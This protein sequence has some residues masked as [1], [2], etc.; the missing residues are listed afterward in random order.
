MTILY[1][2]LPS[3]PAASASAGAS[4][5]IAEHDSFLAAGIEASDSL[6]QPDT[7]A[8]RYAAVADSGAI[9]QQGE[10][11]LEE[12]AGLVTRCSRVVLLVAA[13]DVTL[14]NIVVPP[15]SAARLRAALPNLIE[16][17]LIGDAAE[18]AFVAGPAVNGRRTVAVVAHDWLAAWSQ[19]LRS[20]GA[21]QLTALPAQLCLPW[22]SPAADGAT[23]T[24]PDA[25]GEQAE[26]RQVTAAAI[27]IHVHAME[28]SLRLSSTD[29]LGLTI[30]A[31]VSATEPSVTATAADVLDALMALVPGRRVMALVPAQE[32]ALFEFLL[33]ERQAAQA[34]GTPAKPDTALAPTVDFIADSWTP[35]IAGAATVRLD[36]L[37]GLGRASSSRFDWRPW[38]WPAVLAALLLLVNAGALNYE[39]WRLSRE[40]A[41]LRGA[42][43][44]IYR[45]AYPNETV[46]VD[47]VAQMAQKIAL[48]KRDAGQTGPDDFATLAAKF[49]EAWGSVAMEPAARANIAALDYRERALYVRLKAGASASSAQTGALRAALASRG[50]ALTN[51]PSQT[52]SVVWHI[53]PQGK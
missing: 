53:H 8:C 39:W 34:S 40:A 21:S 4:A 37:A 3:R 26:A 36:L 13:S 38:R 49:G 28:L 5:D 7:L 33:R 23:G 43:T 24:P 25:V 27:S 6:P 48:G 52:S 45:A 11:R 19:R 44:Q 35:W 22:A 18:C 20:M 14:L 15:M 9:E 1:L 41:T 12:L 46:I 31:P 50:L 16:D 47:P 29:G 30:V 2:R 17:Q 51:A 32:Q 10:A 42:L